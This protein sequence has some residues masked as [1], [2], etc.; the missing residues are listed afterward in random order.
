[1]VEATALGAALLAG[2]GAG[3]W[4]PSE[5]ASLFAGVG[6]PRVFTPQAKKEQV[7]AHLARWAAAVAK[8]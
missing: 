8:A 4:K 6:A 3:V 1:M 7:D 5:V 2:I